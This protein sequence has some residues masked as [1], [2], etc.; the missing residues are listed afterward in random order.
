MI[1]KKIA[2]I[3]PAL[4]NLA[5]A[6]AAFKYQDW[7]SIDESILVELRLFTLLL[8]PEKCRDFF[9]TSTT[10]SVFDERMPV[11]TDDFFVYP[12]HYSL[13]FKQTIAHGKSKHFNRAVYIKLLLNHR[14]IIS[15]CFLANVEAIAN[16]VGR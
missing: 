12:K 14:M 10:Y 4:F 5:F 2:A 1:Y 16:S 6:M 7:R 15:H 9:P 11:L 13:T 8:N 3:A